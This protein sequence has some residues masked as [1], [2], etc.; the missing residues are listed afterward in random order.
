MQFDGGLMRVQIEDESLVDTLKQEITSIFSQHNDS[1]DYDSMMEALSEI[2][3]R[4]SAYDGHPHHKLSGVKEAMGKLDVYSFS[5]EKIAEH[6]AK[7]L[8]CNPWHG[9]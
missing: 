4:L 8:D 5:P 6:L 7:E 1:P 2:R 3:S 9:L